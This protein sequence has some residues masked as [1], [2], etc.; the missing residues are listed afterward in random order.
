MKT[1][2]RS[3]I[4]KTLLR[5]QE[6]SKKLKLAESFKRVGRDLEIKDMAEEGLIDYGQQLKTL[7]M[8]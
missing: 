4:G 8:C 5:P 2:R 6:D 1:V 7:N 3:I